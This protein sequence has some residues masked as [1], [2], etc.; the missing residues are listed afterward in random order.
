MRNHFGWSLAIHDIAFLIKEVHRCQ[1]DK[2]QVRYFDFVVNYSK[3]EGGRKMQT[4][5]YGEW[6]SS[7]GRAA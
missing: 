4:V 1:G 3:E 2:E 7:E 6:E 5:A